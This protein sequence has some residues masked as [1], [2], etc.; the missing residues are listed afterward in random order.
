MS[1]TSAQASLA[2]GNSAIEGDLVNSAGDRLQH[3]PAV[4]ETEPRSDAV[5]FLFED[6]GPDKYPPLYLRAPARRTAAVNAGDY[7]LYVGGGTINGAFANMLHDEQGLCYDTN[8]RERCE[9]ACYKQ[10][11]REL[12]AASCKA[13]GAF[14]ASAN[15]EVLT[16]LHLSVACAMAGDATD[17]DSPSHESASGAVFLHVFASNKQPLAQKNMAMLYVVGPKGEGCQGPK[18]GPLL[19]RERFL[20]GVRVL[21]KRALDIVGI[22][23][24]DWAA[25]NPIEEVRWCLV[26]GGVYCH[27]EVQKVEVAAA[28]IHGMRDS[29]VDVLVTFTY[30]ENAF[31][32]AFEESVPANGL[33]TPADLTEPWANDEWLSGSDG[34]AGQ[35]WWTNAD[36]GWWSGSSKWTWDDRSDKCSN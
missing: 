34:W 21:A 5:R 36:S 29:E 23:N 16:E 30:D 25:G 1:Q 7:R 6:K 19:N 33:L 24:H 12:L 35:H 11:H 18:Q 13:G 14:V 20:A 4:A 2:N 15:Q 17:Q 9:L 10:L 31:R 8:V 27:P 3:D 32:Q 28:T 22:Y 26:S